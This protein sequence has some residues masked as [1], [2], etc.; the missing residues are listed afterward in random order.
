MNSLSDNDIMLLV[1]N[2]RLDQLRH[3]F[4][5]HHV[6]LFNYFVRLTGDRMLSEDLTQDVFLRMLRFRHTYKGKGSF[7]SWMFQIARN[8][9][10]DF[11]RK[12][13]KI[14]SLDDR[15]LEIE[16]EHP[17]PLDESSKKEQVHLLQKAM[18]K[19][20]PHHREVLMLA[21]FENMPLKDVAVVLNC[22]VNTVKV[23]VHRAV[24]ELGA[25]YAEL[26]GVS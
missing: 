10:I 26:E 21:R 17:T 16:S 13:K 3:L 9:S 14:D 4:D 8:I 7:T 1:K 2:G 18:L 20:S 6:K 15:F 24:K 11:F 5:R 23:R 12:N 19:L 25:I 22:P